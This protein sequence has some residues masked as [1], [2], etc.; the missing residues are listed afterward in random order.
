MKRIAITSVCIIALT[1]GCVTSSSFQKSERMLELKKASIENNT[2]IR[3]LEIEKEKKERARIE[4]EKALQKQREQQAHEKELVRIRAEKDLQGQREKQAHEKEVAELAARKAADEHKK[5]EE[6]RKLKELRFKRYSTI[7]QGAKDDKI[8]FKAEIAIALAGVEKNGERVLWAEYVRL[9]RML[10]AGL[11][12]PKDSYTTLLVGASAVGSIKIFKLAFLEVGSIEVTSSFDASKRPP[13]LWALY[14]MNQELLSL[15]WS[16]HP[17]CGR[18][19]A[20]G[21]TALHYAAQIGSMRDMEVCL[22]LKPDLVNVAD[23]NGDTPIY[24]AISNSQI[25]LATMLLNNKANLEHKNKDGR[26]PFAYACRK[27]ELAFLELFEKYGAKPTYDDFKAAIEGNHLSVVR[28]FVEQRYFSV[29]GESG[30]DDSII[31]RADSN[32]IVRDYLR[33][34]GAG[35]K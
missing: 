28:W 16:G 12:I 2:R 3:D 11:S 20:F 5:V 21:K 1:C 35:V 34:Q 17:D 8:D 9:L 13:L 23:N 33:K 24:M 7:L 25:D 29:N 32:P 14:G 26:S 10:E 30:K 27:G 18:A 4:G 31:R 22:Q 19:D 6:E 15:V